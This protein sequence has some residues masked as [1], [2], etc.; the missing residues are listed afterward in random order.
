[1]HVCMSQANDN[2]I[3]VPK[4]SPIQGLD[5]HYVLSVRLYS[6]RL[7]FRGLVIP[8]EYFQGQS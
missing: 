1:M 2:F 8:K 4:G 5:V 6:S 7:F 3:A